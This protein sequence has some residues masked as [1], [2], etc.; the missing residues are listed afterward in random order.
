MADR[1]S[2]K[3]AA[4]RII[5]DIG[6]PTMIINN[7]G[8]VQGKSFIDLSEEEIIQTLS[9]NLRGIPMLDKTRTYLGH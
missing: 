9:V 3:S 7:A 4:D 1:S 8:I 5:R 6:Q 2:V